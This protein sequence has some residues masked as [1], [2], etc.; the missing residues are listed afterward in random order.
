MTVDTR[1]RGQSRSAPSS[2]RNSG[3]PQKIPPFRDDTAAGKSPVSPIPEWGRPKS[4][5]SPEYLAPPKKKTHKPSPSLSALSLKLFPRSQG[6]NHFPPPASPSWSPSE[7]VSGEEILQTRLNQQ[8]LRIQE[9]NNRFAIYSQKRDKLLLEIQ[10]LT[11]NG[12]GT[13]V[14]RSK[15]PSGSSATAGGTGSEAM[16]PTPE[17]EGEKATSSFIEDE[18]SSDDSSGE[19]MLLPD[20]PQKKLGGITVIPPPGTKPH[21]PAT[22]RPTPTTGTSTLQIGRAVQ[23]ECRDRSR[24]PSSA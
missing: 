5:Q 12:S 19:D 24:M 16:T 4:E 7:T 21:Q 15:S 8:I 10:K 9:L 22:K 13:P 1:S 2:P 3:T 23:Q 11:E 14:S 18:D 20:S 6:M 17:N